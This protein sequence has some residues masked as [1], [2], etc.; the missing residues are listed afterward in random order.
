MYRNKEN[1]KTKLTDTQFAEKR[2]SGEIEVSEWE[3]DPKVFK[4]NLAVWRKKKSK[5]LQNIA[6]E[7]ENLGV[8][9]SWQYI[10]KIESG[11]KKPSYDFMLYFRFAFDESID[12]IFFNK[13]YY[14]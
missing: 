8:K 5:S 3:K 11:Q 10:Q 13:D 1:K 2:N 6:D 12:D 4:T 7:I 9:Y 14:R